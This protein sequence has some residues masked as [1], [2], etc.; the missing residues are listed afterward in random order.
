[1]RV[2]VTADRCPVDQKDDLYVRFEGIEL[3]REDF[4]AFR[5]RQRQLSRLAWLAV[6]GVA[7]V[8]GF[9]IA[10]LWSVGIGFV[11]AAI[12]SL[13]GYEGVKR[14]NR[15]R[16]M[17]RFPELRHGGFEWKQTSAGWRI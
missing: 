1:V 13:L 17:S 6:V 4:D 3:S 15:A 10:E 14:W 16:W 8:S 11:V 7:M 5:A 2:R 12:A 9:V